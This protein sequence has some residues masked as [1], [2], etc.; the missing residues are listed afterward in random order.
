[1]T[2]FL[3]AALFTGFTGIL[4]LSFLEVCFPDFAWEP[5]EIL[6]CEDAPLW[7]AHVHGPYVGKNRIKLKGEGR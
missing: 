2:G 5:E 3:I 1:M 6:D 4:V 7:L